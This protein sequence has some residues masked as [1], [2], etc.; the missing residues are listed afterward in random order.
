MSKKIV[1]LLSLLVVV[2][3]LVTACGGTTAPEP[4]AA[5]AATAAPVATAAPEPVTGGPTA[6]L[7]IIFVQHALCA[8]DSFWCVVEN[9]IKTAAEQMK[10]EY[11][12]LGP[13]KF[14]L[15]KTAQL[16]DQAVS[17]KPDGLGLTVTDA[18]LFR[19]LVL[20]LKPA[21]T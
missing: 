17:A 15:E 5:P 3:M 7:K 12:V 18:D 4:T 11:T 2:A 20:R 9:G 8:W 16:I 1:S 10:V 13:D 21:P 19:A 14:D 6:R